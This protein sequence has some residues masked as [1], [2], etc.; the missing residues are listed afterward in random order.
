[1]LQYAAQALNVVGILFINMVC[2]G[3]L[4]VGARCTHGLL[5]D[6]TPPT[7]VL[8]SRCH[9]AVSKPW[10]PCHHHRPCT[11]VLVWSSRW[12]TLFEKHHTRSQEARSLAQK[13]FLSQVH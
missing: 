8:L 5:S 12:L 4:G 6:Q 10:P 7:D 13:L 9:P 1:V 2:R 11:Q 3:G